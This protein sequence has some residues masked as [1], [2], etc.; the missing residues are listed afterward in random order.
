MITGREPF[1]GEKAPAVLRAIL[2]E[3]PEPLTGLRSG[4]PMELERVVNKCLT[5]EPGKRYQH[6]DEIAVDLQAVLD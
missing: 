4:V 1:K 5:K 3:E 6:M 2:E